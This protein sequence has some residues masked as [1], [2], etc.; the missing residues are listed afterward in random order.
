MNPKSGQPLWGKSKKDHSKS[1]IVL[2]PQLY[3]QRIEGKPI[4]VP[5]Q[6]I[7]LSAGPC[8][9][10]PSIKNPVSYK[11]ILTSKTETIVLLPSLT[12]KSRVF[13]KRFEAEEIER[14]CFNYI[15]QIIYEAEDES[16]DE[17]ILLL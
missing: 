12:P 4:I 8:H 9:I 14:E 13:V 2:P 16:Q 5:G 11:I 6:S 17:P 7:A 15:D 1:K 10:V 3:I